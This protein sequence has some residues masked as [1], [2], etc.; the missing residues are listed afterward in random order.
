LISAW[1]LKVRQEIQ[2]TPHETIL[3][4]WLLIIFLGTTF[5]VAGLVDI[6]PKVRAKEWVAAPARVISTEIYE[7]RS[8]HGSR[9][10]TWITYQ[11]HAAGNRYISKNI[12]SA[13]TSDAGCNVE[14]RRVE[15]YLE[16]F[17]AGSVID[18]H[19]D[20]EAPGR[21]AIYI[22]DIGFFDVFFV[23][24]AFVITAWSAYLISIARAVLREQASRP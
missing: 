21:A 1:K 19:Y 12:T 24:M 5:L 23:G 17:P 8:T 16:G 6:V 3:G 14:K 9:W 22:E 11:Y 13:I 7:Q 20:P 15:E 4:G 10:C 2:K 18:I